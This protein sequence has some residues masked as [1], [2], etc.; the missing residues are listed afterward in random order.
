MFRGDEWFAWYPVV[1]SDGLA[2]DGLAR[3]LIQQGR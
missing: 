1:V 2:G 3:P